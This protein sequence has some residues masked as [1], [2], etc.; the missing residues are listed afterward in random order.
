MPQDRRNRIHPIT[1]SRLSRSG[2]RQEKPFRSIDE[3]RADTITYQSASLSYMSK[4]V[5][6][7]EKD[8]SLFF[9][10]IG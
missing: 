10:N 8:C 9:I 5:V 4:S 1:K 6:F 3:D 7:T 2:M